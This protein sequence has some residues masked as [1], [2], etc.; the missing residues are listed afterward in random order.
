MDRGYRCG[1]GGW[2]RRCPCDGRR[3]HDREF[4][5]LRRCTGWAEFASACLK[6]FVPRSDSLTADLEISRHVI[7]ADNKKT[8]MKPSL[9]VNEAG[10]AST[11]LHKS[12]L[13]RVAKKDY[14]RKYNRDLG[15]AQSPY[16]VDSSKARH[17]FSMGH[18]PSV[19]PFSRD[20]RDKKIMAQIL[21]TRINEISFPQAYVAG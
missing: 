19:T 21:S 15:F 13:L 6:G 14:F 20:S 4:L 9:F 2:R 5:D 10:D 16:C 8:R 17:L 12:R 1:E 7:G 18:Q 11:V 3:D